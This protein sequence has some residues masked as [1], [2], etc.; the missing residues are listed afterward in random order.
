MALQ[1]AHERGNEVEVAFWKAHLSER[2]DRLIESVTSG[3]SITGTDT[4]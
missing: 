3:A 4:D 1:E 2:L